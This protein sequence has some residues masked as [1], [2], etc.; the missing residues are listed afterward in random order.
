MKKFI[1]IIFLIFLI[2]ILLLG[3]SKELYKITT[4]KESKVFKLL[5]EDNQ[6][7]FDFLNK[8]YYVDKVYY[9]REIISYTD[10]NIRFIDKN[11]DEVFLTG[12][13][14]EVEKIK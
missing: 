12:D 2:T 4:Y 5:D 6:K 10:K 8:R 11:E 13:K 7:T 1:L 3:C 9:A 14:I